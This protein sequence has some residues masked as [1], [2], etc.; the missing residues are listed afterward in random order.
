VQEVLLRSPYPASSGAPSYRSL[1]EYAKT[2][3]IIQKLR[4]LY[5]VPLLLEYD[6]NVYRHFFPFQV[7]QTFVIMAQPQ[8]QLDLKVN[9]ISAMEIER[10]DTKNLESDLPMSAEAR[11]EMLIAQ[12]P[13]RNTDKVYRKE[14]LSLFGNQLNY[15]QTC[16]SV[17]YVF[18]GLPTNLLL[19]RIRPSIFIPC[20]E[21]CCLICDS[22]FCHR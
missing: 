17:G 1:I 8:S 3:R 19:T 5:I 18:G 21:V 12:V 11:T 10:S 7:I 20:V 14:D 2:K 16:Y 6:F 15:M 4:L 22:L 13:H 9:P